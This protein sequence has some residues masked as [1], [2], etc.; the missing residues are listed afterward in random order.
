MN[1]IDEKFDR[2][3]AIINKKQNP[4]VE[5]TVNTR[6]EKYNLNWRIQKESQESYQNQT[7][8]LK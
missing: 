4:V 1:E 6:V 3:V 5:N 2:K 8:M 7:H